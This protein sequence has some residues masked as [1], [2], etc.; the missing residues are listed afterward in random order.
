MMK[1]TLAS[2]L[3]VLGLSFALG[4]GQAFAADAPASPPPPPVFNSAEAPA[5]PVFNPTSDAPAG[6]TIL[7]GD[8]ANVGTV[9]QGQPGQEDKDYNAEK[10]SDSAVAAPSISDEQQI[11]NGMESAYD[12]YHSEDYETCGKTTSAIL[13]RFPKRKL[14]WVEYLNGLALE[15]QELYYPALKSYEAVLKDAPHSTYSNAAK[16]RIGLC[17]LKSGQ[18]NEAVFT[19]R[20]IIENNPRSE[21]R[22]QAYVHLG[23]LYRDRRKW[24]AAERIYRDIIRLYPET[25]WAWTSAFY[26]AETHSHRGDLEPAIRVYNNLV[27]DP[28]VPESLRAQARLRIGDLYLSDEKWLEALQTYRMALRDFSDVPGVAVTCEEKMRI[29]TDGRKHSHLAYRQVRTGPH[30]LAEPE[31]EQ[32]RLKQ[33]QEKIPYQ[34]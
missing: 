33:E 27:R 28:E 24:D 4:S 17:Q 7:P 18:A 10:M 3:F 5:A 14:F 16:F 29:A 22:L 21:Y 15:H 30:G 34:Q 26:L 19:L 8:D 31:D 20:D 23:N 9:P 12:E 25:S 13:E 1:Q 6:P 32:Y 2:S 11:R